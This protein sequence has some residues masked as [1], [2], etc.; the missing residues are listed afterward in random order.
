M[1]SHLKPE[2]VEPATLACRVSR[3]SSY[4]LKTGPLKGFGLRLRGVRRDRGLTQRELAKSSGLSHR[5]I[6]YYEQDDAQPPGAI[7]VAL[8]RAL[9]VSTDELLGLK[10]PP[11]QI[12]LRASRLRKRLQT[13]EQLPPEDQRA[14]LK[15][16]DSLRLA[17]AKLD[18]LQK[19]DRERRQAA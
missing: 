16:V 17:R 1:S 7:V 2:A 5:M 18:D 10:T 11:S 9:H 8:A 12:S 6:A 19:G 4:S 14:V 13:V 15:F 3:R